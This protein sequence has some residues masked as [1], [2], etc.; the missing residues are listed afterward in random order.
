MPG[1]TELELLKTVSTDGLKSYQVACFGLPLLRYGEEP[2]GVFPNKAS[3]LSC[4]YF[5]F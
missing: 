1:S 5:F 2:L 3:M 4:C